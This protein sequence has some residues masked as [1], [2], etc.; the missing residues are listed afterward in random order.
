MSLLQIKLQK[1]MRRRFEKF[2]R[3]EL[4]TFIMAW[5]FHAISEKFLRRHAEAI[6]LKNDFTILDADR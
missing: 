6:G 4:D 3:V 1:E 2:G 5:H